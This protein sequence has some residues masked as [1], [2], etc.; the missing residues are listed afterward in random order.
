MLFPYFLEMTYFM[1]S[2]K[3]TKSFKIRTIIGGVLELF[4]WYSPNGMGIKRK[5]LKESVSFEVIENCNGEFLVSKLKERDNLIIL[6]YWTSVKPTTYKLD[7]YAMNKFYRLTW[8]S[9]GTSHT[10]PSSGYFFFSFYIYSF[11]YINLRISIHKRF[12]HNS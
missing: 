10:F 7:Y 11:I 2:N 3:L 4:S 8:G 9:H 12:F 5:L 6:Y 1:S